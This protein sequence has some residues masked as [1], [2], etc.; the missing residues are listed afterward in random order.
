MKNLQTWWKKWLGALILVWNKQVK[1]PLPG[2][3]KTVCRKGADPYEM[4]A[5]PLLGVFGAL[6]VF[7]PGVVSLMIFSCFGS[8]LLFALL[9]GVVWLFHDFGRGDGLISSRISSFLPEKNIPYHIVIPVVMLVLKLAL[10]TALFFHG[11]GLFL[12]AIWAGGLAIEALLIRDAELPVM[13]FSDSAMRS[14]WIAMSLVLLLNVLF[15]PF[16]SAL[17]ALGFAI[18]WK[19]ARERITTTGNM[20]DEIR[21]SGA[22]CSWILLLIGVLSI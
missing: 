20:T 14:F 15:Q 5:F 3:L 16:G 13:D 17:G 21:F 1:F 9:A 7:L 11:A 4:A 22:V 19:A 12:T 10:L 8:S 18:W 6:V 2:K